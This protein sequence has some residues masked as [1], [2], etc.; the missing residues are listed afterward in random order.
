MNFNKS[1]IRTV[2][3]QWLITEQSLGQFRTNIVFSPWRKK[4]EKNNNQCN[5]QEN[6]KMHTY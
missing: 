2:F 6:D 3:F 5:I 4:Q 1:R